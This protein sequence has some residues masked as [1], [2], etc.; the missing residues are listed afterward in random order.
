GFNY[1]AK[2]YDRVRGSFWFSVKL[3]FGVLLGAALIGLLFAPGIVEVFLRGNAEVTRIGALSLRLQCITLP[4]TGF[5]ILSNM[6]L[7]TMGMAREAS[8]VAVSRQG[9][10]FL[11]AIFLLPPLLG[12]FGVQLSQP[13]SDLCSLAMTAPL[14]L[15]VLKD[16]KRKEARLAVEGDAAHA[17]V[18]V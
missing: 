14:T 5:L 16:L 2:R 18:P 9:L 7:Q 4:L 8:L 6:M 15:R 3:S 13:V 17:H 1:G 12:L 10:F 11:P